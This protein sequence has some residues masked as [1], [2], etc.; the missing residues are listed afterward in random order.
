M[1]IHFCSY[2]LID[3]Y[4][5]IADNL[6]TKE[7]SMCRYL[8]SAIVFGML[9]MSSQAAFTEQLKC[10]S[11]ETLS[12][13]AYVGSFPFGY[14]KLT[15]HMTAVAAAT[16]HTLSD[17]DE[18][19]D[20]LLVV[21][22]MPVLDTEHPKKSMRPFIDQLTLVR[23]DSF[24]YRL[25]RDYAIDVCTYILPGKQHAHAL[26]YIDQPEVSE[27]QDAL[28]QAHHQRFVE[29]LSQQFDLKTLLMQ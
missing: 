18:S 13:Y 29:K 19:F 1:L 27:G 14:D 28:H 12:S 16:P 10:P 5:I 24:L 26:L 17:L 15:Q 7:K 23:E 4:A 9:F 2:S 21:Y 25:S 11:V 6:I 20:R 3:L 22:G 8:R